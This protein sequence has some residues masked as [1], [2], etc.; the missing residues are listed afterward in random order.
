MERLNTY[1]KIREVARLYGEGWV[2]E[3]IARQLDVPRIVIVNTLKFICDITTEIE[4]SP[5]FGAICEEPDDEDTLDEEDIPED[6]GPDFLT[7]GEIMHGFIMDN[8]VDAV[9]VEEYYSNRENE[10]VVIFTEKSG[11]YSLAIHKET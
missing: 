6:D 10:A 2:I 9:V 1:D 8:F 7:M 5:V 11:E 3:E 4:K